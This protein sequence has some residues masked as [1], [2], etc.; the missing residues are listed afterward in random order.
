MLKKSTILGGIK[1]RL[2]HT[3]L[4]RPTKIKAKIIT[5]S[6]KEYNL[7]MGCTQ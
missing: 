7:P 4:Y 6:G 2:T 5:H 3:S 1:H